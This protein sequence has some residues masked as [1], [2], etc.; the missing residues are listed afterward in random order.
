MPEE[1]KSVVVTPELHEYL[2]AHGSPPDAIQLDL[3]SET[4]ALGPIAGMQISPEQG[5]FMELLVRTVAA[6]VVVEVGTFTGYSALCMARGLPPDGRLIACDVNEEWTSIGR[7]YWDRAGVGGKIELRIAP[8]S[9]TLSA[10]PPDLLVDLA[11]IDAD[12]VGYATYYEELL[13][14]MSTGGL[15]LVDN[16]LWSGRVVDESVTDADTVAI[17]DFNDFVAADDR[18]DV[19]M[20][21][22][23]DGLSLIRVK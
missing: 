12:K 7:R 4:K 6:R 1:P 19:V 8:A 21:P 15:I 20:L 22:I 5:A 11:F 18:V 14:R 23:A 17:R 9:V 3:I 13:K 10:L 2:V 16:V